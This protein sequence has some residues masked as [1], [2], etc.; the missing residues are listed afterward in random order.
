MRPPERGREALEIRMGRRFVLFLAALA[1]A[2]AA[3][4]VKPMVSEGNRHGLALH[5]DGTVRSWGDDSSGQLGLGRT[6]Q[7]SAPAIVAGIANVAEV[8]SGSGHVVARLRDGTVWAWGHNDVGQLGD[9][10]TTNRSTPAPVAGLAN[11]T[12]IA[13]GFEHNLALRADGTVWSWGVNY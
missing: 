2:C 13:A 9:G 8:G 11:V 10:T 6:L 3:H 12:A 1:A 7:A 4:A 5:S